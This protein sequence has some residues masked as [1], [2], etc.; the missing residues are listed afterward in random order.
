M[1]KT[2]LQVSLAL[3]LPLAIVS[4]NSG[5][6]VEG[7]TDGTDSLTET[8][9]SAEA[10]LTEVDSL[11]E[12]VIET[13]D[14]TVTTFAEG[15]FGYS[16]QQFLDSEEAGEKSFALD[17][18]V[19]SDEEGDDEELSEEGELQLDELASLLKSHPDAKAEIQGHTKEANNALSKATK[20][21]VSKARAF[22]IRKKLIARGVSEDQLRHEGYGDKNLL[23][24]VDGKDASQN[25]IEVLFTK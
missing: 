25:R 13:L 18:I 8:I 22:F 21:G 17:Q 5:S 9:D 14:S 16:L 10:E 11:A 20:K 4:C 3:A 15:T 19:I 7:T 2:I 1:K 12:E 6:E 24:G 23:E